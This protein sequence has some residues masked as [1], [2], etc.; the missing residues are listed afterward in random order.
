MGT[1]VPGTFLQRVLNVMNR[2]ASD[3][4]DIRSMAVS[5]P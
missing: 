2:Q 5:A 4:P 1:S 3:Y